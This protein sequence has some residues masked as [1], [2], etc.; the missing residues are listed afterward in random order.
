MSTSSQHKWITW[1][2]NTRSA[3]HKMQHGINPIMFHLVPWL[4]LILILALFLMISKKITIAPGILFNLPSSPIS[5]GAIVSSP[6]IVL[7]KPMP[8]SESIAFFDDIRFRLDDAEEM[9]N[10]LSLI[11]SKQ[12]KTPS[13]QLTLFA[14]TD[15][16]HGEIT[17]L[18]AILK[19]AGI[20]SVNVAIKWDKK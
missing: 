16:T 7:L 19:K 18:T 11:R 1:R 3:R 6:S 4:N 2:N 20:A 13:S 8:D 10:L 15:V 17:T 12:E 5:E 9:N 14:A